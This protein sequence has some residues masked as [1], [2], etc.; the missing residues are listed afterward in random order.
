MKKNSN[1]KMLLAA[2]LGGCCIAACGC[3]QKKPP[4][5]PLETGAGSR[6]SVVVLRWA[7]G[8]SGQKTRLQV[9]ALRGAGRNDFQIIKLEHAFGI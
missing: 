4:Q 5:A 2:V 3:G 9:C 1:L 7:A 8:N 6:E